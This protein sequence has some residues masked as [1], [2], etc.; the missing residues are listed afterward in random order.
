LLFALPTFAQIRLPNLPQNPNAPLSFIS[1]APVAA[2]PGQTV[3]VHVEGA[4]FLPG[5]NFEIGQPAGVTVLR[6]AIDNPRQAEIALVV[7]DNA[8]P[9]MRPFVVARGRDRVAARGDSSSWR[10]KIRLF[11]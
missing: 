2:R 11:G 4:G 6:V 10:N 7:E 9:G 3:T 5:T 1:F 8:S